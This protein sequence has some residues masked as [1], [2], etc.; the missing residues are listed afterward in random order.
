M[1]NNNNNNNSN[2]VPNRKKPSKKASK[3]GQNVNSNSYEHHLERWLEN[4]SKM[5]FDCNNLDGNWSIMNASNGAANHKKNN[6]HLQY[7]SADPISL[8]A[9]MVRKFRN[10]WK[11]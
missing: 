8:P 2:S 4:T 3:N 11:F 6:H 1:A 7:S 10:L 9:H 5:N